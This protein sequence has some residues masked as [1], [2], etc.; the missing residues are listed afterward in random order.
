M[1]RK[2]SPNLFP[3][4]GVYNE[5][6]DA[7]IPLLKKEVLAFAHQTGISSATVSDDFVHE[8]FVWRKPVF[9]WTAILTGSRL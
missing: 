2:S 1:K 4:P 5:D 6:V 7:D 9:G 8:W 3:L